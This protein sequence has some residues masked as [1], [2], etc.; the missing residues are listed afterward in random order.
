VMLHG[1]LPTFKADLQ[2]EDIAKKV[3][4]ILKGKVNEPSGSNIVVA[5]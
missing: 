3:I 4:D 1:L 2:P 5:K